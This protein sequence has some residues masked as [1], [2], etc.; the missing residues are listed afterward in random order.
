MYVP[1]GGESASASPFSSDRRPPSKRDTSNAA[2]MSRPEGPCTTSACSERLLSP[3][4]S[5]LD[6]LAH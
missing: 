5:R 2:V 4:A 6:R 3:P 1:G